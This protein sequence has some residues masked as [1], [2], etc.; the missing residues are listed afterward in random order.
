[1]ALQPIL[2]A[3]QTPHPQSETAAASVQWNKQISPAKIFPCTQVRYHFYFYNPSP[4]TQRI[5]FQNKWPSDFRITSLSS[6]S[7]GGQV[8]SGVDS[9]LLDIRQMTLQPGTDSL[10]VQ[11]AVGPKAKGYYIDRSILFTE[12]KAGSIQTANTSVGSP[13]QLLVHPLHI[14][15]GQDTSFFCQK[16]PAPLQAFDHPDLQY[17]WMN[18]TTGPNC[19]IEKSGWYSLEVS[20]G[21]ETATD[22]TYVFL[23]P[24]FIDMDE[25]QFLE[26]GESIVLSPTTYTIRNDLSYHWDDPLGESLDCTDCPSP[27]AIP[28][29]DVMYTLTV[30]SSRGCQLKD[31]IFVEVSKSREVYIPNAFSPNLDGLNE[32][33]F[34]QGKGLAYVRRFMIYNRKGDLVFQDS[35]FEVND[36]F[37][38]WDG[39][40]RGQSAEAGVYIYAVEVEFL[41]GFTQWYA[42]DVSL[43]R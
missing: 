7:L 28:L 17:K 2:C 20:N 31:S 27:T 30:Q 18:G 29:S 3:Q 4:Q 25:R 6:S 1:M 39:T 42:G 10:V 15:L 8:Q 24:L 22:S 41:D 12:S 40:Y 38:G 16:R 11:L 23:D 13:I 35:D 5:S 21:C 37:H 32:V 33:L 26:L 14:D 43:L 34:V 9:R 19:P 36:M